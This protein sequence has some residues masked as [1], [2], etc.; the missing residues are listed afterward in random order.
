M[1]T[2]YL[3]QSGGPAPQQAP[4]EQLLRAHLSE[5]APPTA[6]A[7]AAA[8]QHQAGEKAFFWRPTGRSLLLEM[9]VLLAALE[10]SWATERSDA[11]SRQLVAAA[12][13][14]QPARPH[15]P[16]AGRLY[17][18]QTESDAQ[19][20]L[21]AYDYAMHPASATQAELLAFLPLGLLKEAWVWGEWMD[22]KAGG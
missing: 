16:L 4:L 8:S 3:L 14:K 10:P 18:L 5:I 19:L 9:P 21:R 11:F 22:M 20:L 2:L 12:A 17:T 13:N 7:F 6:A 1:P 15:L